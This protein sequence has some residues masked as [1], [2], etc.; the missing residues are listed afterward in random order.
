MSS[1]YQIQAFCKIPLHLYQEAITELDGIYG[2]LQSFISCLE[3]SEYV[4]T[5]DF[6]EI[7]A[8]KNWLDDLLEQVQG[9]WPEIQIQ[10]YSLTLNERISQLIDGCIDISQFSQDQALA[11]AEAAIYAS[12]EGLGLETGILDL[13]LEHD[14]PDS[15]GK[16]FDVWGEVQDYEPKLIYLGLASKALNYYFAR[17]SQAE[18]KAKAA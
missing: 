6:P 16:T 3:A 1:S 9:L 14:F 17:Y 2:G 10:D 11:L 8:C 12:S 15:F 13:R 4:I 5:S 18:S 7:F